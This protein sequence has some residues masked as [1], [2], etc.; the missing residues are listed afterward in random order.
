MFIFLCPSTPVPSLQVKAPFLR[1]V[2][3]SHWQS[4]SGINIKK[5]NHFLTN[6]FCLCSISAFSVIFSMLLTKQLRLKLDVSLSICIPCIICLFKCVECPMIGS[7][8]ARRLE[9]NTRVCLYAFFAFSTKCLSSKLPKRHN[10][11]IT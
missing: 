2:L 8:N 5:Y 1:K 9:A 3:E 10:E 6:N 11:K 7:P 4:F